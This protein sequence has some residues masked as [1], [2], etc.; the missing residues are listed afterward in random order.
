MNT[1]RHLSTVVA[2]ITCCIAFTMTTGCSS[3]LPGK[4]EFFQRKVKA[5]PEKTAQAKEFEKQAA[6]ELTKNVNE[7]YDEATKNNATNSVIKPLEKAKTVAPALA[8]S[9]GPPRTEWSGNSTNLSKSL[10][11]QRAELDKDLEKYKNKVDK[12]V[13]K[14]IE[15]TGLIQLPYFVFIGILFAIAC[16]AWFALKVLALANPGVG[17]GVKVAQV[18]GRA[19]SNMLSEVIEAGEEFKNQVQK[20]ISDLEIQRHVLELFRQAHLAKQS[21]ETQNTIKKLT[22]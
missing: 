21:R 17:V 4:V 16:V 1:R 9:L 3:L 13:G 8:E 7:A 10:Y 22:N 5:V 18:G 14:E 20:K 19:A 12:N 2:L 15:D 11:K 6:R